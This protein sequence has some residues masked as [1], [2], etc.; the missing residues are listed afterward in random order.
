MREIIRKFLEQS[1]EQHDFVETHPLHCLLQLAGPQHAQLPPLASL[2]EPALHPIYIGD[3]TLS[4]NPSWSRA[5]LC[6]S[7][8]SARLRLGL[9]KTS[10]N[11]SWCL[12]RFREKLNMFEHHKLV[13]HPVI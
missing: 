12:P 8:P 11:T 2:P 13:Q 5:D 9:A 3:S 7:P 10:L 1:W 4:T 6:T